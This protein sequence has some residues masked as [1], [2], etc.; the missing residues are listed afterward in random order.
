MVRS[1]DHSEDGCQCL[2]ADSGHSAMQVYIEH[3][4]LTSRMC[5]IPMLL[6][7]RINPSRVSSVVLRDASV[8]LTSVLHLSGRPCASPYHGTATPWMH[9]RDSL[10]AGRLR[11]R[12]EWALAHRNRRFPAGSVRCQHRECQP[13]A[14]LCFRM[15]PVSELRRC[16]TDCRHI[17]RSGSSAIGASRAPVAGPGGPAIASQQ[18]VASPPISLWARLSQS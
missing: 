2:A 9:R 15:P 1:L 16:L 11:P 18:H 7:T 10:R 6:S 12:T 17:D 13:D 5:A 8:V 3:E 14:L 4:S